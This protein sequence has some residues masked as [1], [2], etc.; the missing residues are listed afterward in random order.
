MY[1]FLLTS[2]A[3]P[4]T[5]E[6]RKELKDKEMES[7]SSTGPLRTPL[8]EHKAFVIHEDSDS[9]GPLCSDVKDL[10][11]QSPRTITNARRIASRKYSECTVILRFCASLL[12]SLAW[13]VLIAMICVH[14]RSSTLFWF[15][16]PSD[17]I[18][19]HCF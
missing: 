3:V 7:L 12:V 5:T 19:A 8:L 1:R 15:E 10:S 13:A 2:R 4:T 17:P 18:V 6:V 9:K 11:L 14:F 16:F